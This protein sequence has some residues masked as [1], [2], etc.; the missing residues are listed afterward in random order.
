M[1]VVEEIG[2]DALGEV[3]LG[4]RCFF[5]TKCVLS[6]ESGRFVSESLA[7]RSRLAA[8][9]NELSANVA[10]EA[11]QKDRPRGLFYE[12]DDVR[13]TIWVFAWSEM[14][15]EARARLEFFR[16]ALD[17]SATSESAQQHLKKVYSKYLPSEREVEFS[18][19]PQPPEVEVAT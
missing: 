16:R 11:S 18:E 6:Y 1:A 17:Y 9:S 5:A 4:A 13:M 10:K 12:D 15:E 19:S 2:T 14:I 7:R 8:L 3:A